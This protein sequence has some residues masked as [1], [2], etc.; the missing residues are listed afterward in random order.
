MSC[1]PRLYSTHG[2]YQDSRADSSLMAA[3]QP[4]SCSLRLQHLG[5]QKLSLA[6]KTHLYDALQA[7]FPFSFRATSSHRPIGD[8]PS[9]PFCCC[10]RHN[11]PLQVSQD[12]RASNRS[13]IRL[14][15]SLI[16]ATAVAHS[17]QYQLII[18]FAAKVARC[19]RVIS[20]P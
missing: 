8:A 12:G 4:R 13:L 7:K 15:N 19:C 16:I 6:T 5:N 17:P 1:T 18:T 2:I 10:C 3:M 9:V 14:L 20:A 11:A